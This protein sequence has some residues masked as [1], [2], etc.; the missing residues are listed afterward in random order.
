M[1][2][3][4]ETAAQ[5]FILK[6]A[7]KLVINMNSFKKYFYHK[8]IDKVSSPLGDVEI[9]HSPMELVELSIGAFLTTDFRENSYPI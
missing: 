2:K 7:K 9:K 4:N 1:L 8:L 6:S 5:N 3:Q